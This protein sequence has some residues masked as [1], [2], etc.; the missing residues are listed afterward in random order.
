MRYDKAL[1][2]STV[3]LTQMRLYTTLWNQVCAQKLQWSRANWS[4]VPCK[5]QPFKTV[6]QKYSLNNVSII[7]FTDEKIFTVTPPKNPQNGR[8]YAYPSTKKKDAVTKC[9]RTQLTFSHWWHQS[10]RHKCLTLHQFDTCRSRSQGHWRVL[11]VT[12][13]C[14]NS[15]CPPY[16]TSDLKRVLRLSA[17]QCPGAY[18]AWGNQ[19]FLI[20]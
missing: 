13:C 14:Y 11:I 3:T 19:I 15:S 7:L 16:R 2:K 1:Y 4:E 6:A 8:L 20:T 5:T 17:G 9:L 12:W 10:A 18:G